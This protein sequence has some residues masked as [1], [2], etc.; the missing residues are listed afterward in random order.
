L[1]G[2]VDFSDGNFYYK[3]ELVNSNSYSD[4][5]KD[6]AYVNQDVTLRHGST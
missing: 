1:L 4:I 6:I 3:G 2:F 5:R